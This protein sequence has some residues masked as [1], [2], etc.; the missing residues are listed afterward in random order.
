MSLDLSSLDEAEGTIEDLPENAIPPDPQTSRKRL[1]RVETW[2][3]VK[4]KKF[5]NQGNAYLDRK[6]KV[7]DAKKMLEYNHQ[8]WY[9]CN[10][11]LPDDKRKEVFDKCWELGSWEL[12][13]AFLNGSIQ[14]NSIKRKK[15]DAANN[16]SV[17]CTYSLGGFRVCQEFFK[18]TLSVSNKRIQNV[19]NNKKKTPCGVS[20]RDKRGKKVPANK[21]LPEKIEII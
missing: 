7:H 16:K 13:T 11:N 3:Q 4:A 21:I 8:C 12:Q 15:V 2:K 19:V 20:P 14:S 5:R 1:R 9:K 18:K 17:S 6:G 10:E